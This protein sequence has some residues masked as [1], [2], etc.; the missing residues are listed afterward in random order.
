MKTQNNEKLNY[1][2]P[3][4]EVIQLDNIISLALESTP[5]VGPLEGSMKV[6]E[7]L[8]IDPFKREFG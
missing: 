5:P 2:I 1:C 8:D 3:K 6:M 4:I 7:H